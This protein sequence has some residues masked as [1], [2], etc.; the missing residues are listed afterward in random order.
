MPMLLYFGASGFLSFKNWQE[1]FLVPVSGARLKGTK[2]EDNFHLNVKNRPMKSVLLFGDNA[3][4]KTNWVYALDRFLFIIR[5][6][7]HVSSREPFNYRSSS[8]RFMIS[9]CNGDGR[10]YEYCLEYDREG[11]VLYESL[12]QDDKVIFT[13]ADE[14]LQLADHVDKRKQ[15][16]ELF[17]QK[18][19]DTLLNKL[20]DWLSDSITEFNHLASQILV[21]AEKPINWEMKFLPFMII[22]EYEQ[23][24]MAEYSDEVLRILQFL[25]PTI[26]NISF[27]KVIDKDGET[28]YQMYVMRLDGDKNEKFSITSESQGIKKM[29]YLLPQ[30][31]QIYE[32]KTVVIDELD[33]SIGTKSLI[34][35][36]NTIVNSPTNTKGQLIVTSH[37]LNLLNLDMFH[38][39]Q[40]KVFSKGDDLG[41][42]INSIDQYDYRSIKKNLDEIYLRG[43][44]AS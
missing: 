42:V 12:K 35:I 38:E 1:M 41:S 14:I 13:F 3:S 18:S 29:I 28:K 24:I 23:S 43:G 34:R 40:L 36:F 19:T 6:G 4:G 15:I 7:L 32:G 31:L 26:H 11:V 17:S 9:V 2:Y 21:D 10:E 20:K 27:E 8:I 33:S 16:Q 25:D 22:E 37:N 5:N 30:L 44:F 39:A